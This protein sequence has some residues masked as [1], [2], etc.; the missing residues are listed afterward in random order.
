MPFVP[1][2]NTALV[3]F[4]MTAN[5][6]KVENTI[7]AEFPSPPAAAD[8]TSLINA[9][10]SWWVAEYATNVSSG[11]QLR[12]ISA[13]SMD[14][15]TAPQVSLAPVSP[16]FGA[17]TANIVPGNVTLTVS[18]RTALRGRSFRG[19]NY[20]VGL[21][22]D[23][24]AGNQAV[25][26]IT[27]LWAGHY[28]ALI[29]AIAGAGFEWVVVSRFSGVDPVT[30]DPIPRAAG[31]TTPVISVVVVDDNLDSQR[32]RLTGRGQ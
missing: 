25:A 1:V 24:I 23:Q 14:S 4:R 7:W 6:Q 16:T 18:F 13:T 9:C 10:E 31:I 5:G 8:L 20:I 22:E 30:H 21:T 3:E 26:G 17:S 15:A 29:A 2:A 28:T 32:R 11:V 27:S 12:E 19:R